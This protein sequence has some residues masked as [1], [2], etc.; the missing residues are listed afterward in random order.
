MR[1]ENDRALRRVRHRPRIGAAAR[2]RGLA[3]TAAPCS[4]GSPSPLP[5]LGGR[6]CPSARSRMLPSGDRWAFLR[7]G[8]PPVPREAPWCLPG[9]GQVSTLPVARAEAPS[10][11]GGRFDELVSRAAT[12]RVGVSHRA[13]QLL[14][15]WCFPRPVRLARVPRGTGRLRRPRGWRRIA[16]QPVRGR[17]GQREPGSRRPGI[18]NGTDLPR[19]GSAPT[20]NR[21]LRNVIV[22]W[23]TV[24]TRPPLNISPPAD[25]HSTPPTWPGL[26]RSATPRSTSMA[27]TGPPAD[28]PPPGSGQ[29]GPVSK[30]HAAAGLVRGGGRLARC[31]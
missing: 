2:S 8:P 16:R 30:N 13:A 1:S 22:L 19:A 26:P 20:C 12:V 5:A 6:C 11:P 14:D 18:R 21:A 29:Y 9:S 15:G 4:L 10:C 27:G 24:Y 28:H 23:Q 3:C 17:G 31:R 7:R 25:T